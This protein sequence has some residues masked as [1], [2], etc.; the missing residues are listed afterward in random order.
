MPGN[1]IDTAFPITG[2]RAN[3]IGNGNKIF[4]E[5]GVLKSCYKHYDVA[6]FSTEQTNVCYVMRLRYFFIKFI[7]LLILYLHFFE[8]FILNI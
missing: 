7:S 3:S 4:D 1:S 6:A 2:R 8:F 5:S